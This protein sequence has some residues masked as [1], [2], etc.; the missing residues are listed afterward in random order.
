MTQAEIASAPNRERVRFFKR[1]PADNAVSGHARLLAGPSYMQFVREEPMLRRV[2]PI[3]ILAFFAIIALWRTGELIEKHDSLDVTARKEMQLMATLLT[4]R[5]GNQYDLFTARVEQARKDAQAK[6]TA[7]K[8][9]KTKSNGPNTTSPALSSALSTPPGKAELQEWLFSAFPDIDLAENYQIFLT[10]ANGMIVAAIPRDETDMRKTLIDLLGRSQA[11]STFGAS[12]GVLDITLPGNE[13]A[14]AAVHHLGKGRGSVILMR[15]ANT[16]FAAWRKDVARSVIAFV[17]MSGLIILIVYAFFSQGARA[18]EA[19]SMYAST[20]KR[21][22]AALKRSHSGL[23]DWNLACGHIYWSHSMYELLGLEPKDELMGFAAINDR[24][25]PDDGN[26]HQHIESLLS[27]EKRMMDQ[28]FRLRHEDGHW[29]WFQIRAELTLSAKNRLHLMGVAMDVSDQVARAKENE[30][31]DLR[32]R[33]AVDAISEAFVLWD[34]TSRLVLCNHQYRQLHGLDDKT[35]LTGLTYNEVMDLGEPQV[36]S[37][38][39]TSEIDANERLTDKLPNALNTARTYKLALSDGRWLQINERRTGDGGFVSVGTDITNLKLQEQRLVDSEQQL[40]TTVSDLRKSRQTLEMQAQQLVVLTEK[41]AKEKDNAE[42]ANRVKSQFLANISHELRTPLNAIIGFSEVM[43][44]EIFGEHINGKYRDYSTD[45]HASGSY[46]LGLIN[47]IL[48]MSRLE[49]GEIDLAPEQTDLVGLA[50][51]ACQEAIPPHV[52]KR[53]LV[54]QDRLPS[55]LQAFAD[56]DMVEQVLCNLLDNAVKFSPEGGEITL[57]GCQEHGYANLT[58]ADSG[59]GIPQDAI[60]RLGHPFEQVQNQ[61]TKTHKGSGLGLSIARR[62]VCL[63]GGTMKIRS[64]IGEGTRVT[65]RLPLAASH[66]VSGTN[67]NAGAQASA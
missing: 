29:V 49:D 56:P 52:E 26:L 33:D 30:V 42:A 59:V 54:L 11:L 55:E 40:I 32:L 35:N 1:K 64:R 61:F 39:D 17:A 62:I 31:A 66:P 10:D 8:K 65:V 14:F 3:L 45:I 34:H 23:W 57:T 9:S 50:R 63:S 21:M 16:L 48:N 67:M 27:S 60:D 53:G 36:I 28:R 6:A 20:Y 7:D 2:I 18:R 15:N 19:D 25:H 51:K 4:E 5:V 41:Y 43:K 47:D 38:E 58:I 13:A 12:A 37:V 22:D 24:M 46:L 44:Q